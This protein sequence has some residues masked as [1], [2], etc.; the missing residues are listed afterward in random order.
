MQFWED[1]K[2]KIVETV[3]ETFEDEVATAT[4]KYQDSLNIF[5]QNYLKDAKDQTLEKGYDEINNYLKKLKSNIDENTID[6]LEY[7]QI[8][9]KIINYG[10]SQ[11]G[12]N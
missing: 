1:S 8:K 3:K 10:Q 12:G 6:S 7:Q 9:K 4:Q 5:M 2:K 11:K